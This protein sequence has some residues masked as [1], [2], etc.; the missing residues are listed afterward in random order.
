MDSAARK[1][2]PTQAYLRGT[3]SARY[4]PGVPANSRPTPLVI[5]GAGGHGRELLDVVEA[6]N[7]TGATDFDVVGVLDDGDVDGDLLA[8]R[9]LRHLGPVDRLRE[10]GIPY[11]IGI[12]SGAARRAI[13]EMAGD[14]APPSVRHPAATLGS[15]IRTGPG[16]VVAAG[17]RLTT[18]I[19]LGRHTH[20]GVNSTVGHDAVLGDYVTV[21]PGATVSGTVR[22]EDGVTIG[23]GAAIIQGVTIGAGTFVGAGAVVIDD[24]P[25]AVTAVGV[26]ARPL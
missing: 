7:E 25:P 26:P 24:L 9:G 21:L 2:A 5:V 18:N 20:V 22:L 6:T 17:A 23:T 14:L 10:L 3:R 12:G 16:S 15:Q 1:K 13:D 4:S 8:A 11:L 19:R